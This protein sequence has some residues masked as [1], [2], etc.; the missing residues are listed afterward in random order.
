MTLTYQE[1]K[2][3]TTSH[4][5]E[6]GCIPIPSP[7]PPLRNQTDAVKTKDQTVHEPHLSLFQEFSLRLLCFPAY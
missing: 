5:A 3:R 1:V 2:S 6:Y 7:P 4:T